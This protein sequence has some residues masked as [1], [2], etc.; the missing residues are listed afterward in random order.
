MP[1]SGGHGWQVQAGNSVDPALFACKPKCVPRFFKRFR[2]VQNVQ[3]ARMFFSIKV[4]QPFAEGGAHRP[5]TRYIGWRACR[6]VSTATRPDRLRRTQ[7][8][9]GV[10]LAT[11]GTGPFGQATRF[12]YL[13]GRLCDML[14]SSG[15]C[16]TAPNTS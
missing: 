1:A 3:R 8:S 15:S 4:H 9:V 12:Q 10:E 5:V 11:T 7:A 14:P 16:P 6:R 2:R 13:R